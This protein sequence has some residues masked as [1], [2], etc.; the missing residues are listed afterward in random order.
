MPERQSTRW[1]RRKTARPA[2]ILSAALDCFAERGFAAT[3]LDDI[4]ARAG[5]TKGTLYLYFPSKEELFKAL[6]REELL[7]NLERLEAAASGPGTAA[8]LLGRLLSVWAGHVV[9]SRISVL[10]KLMIAEAGNFPELAR[11]YLREVIRRGLRLLRSILRRG[12]EAGEFRP[13]DVEHTTYCV[14]GPLLFSVLWKHSF[15]PH[16]DR[17]LDVSALCRAH[18]DALL[19]GLRRPTAAGRGKRPGRSSRKEPARDTEHR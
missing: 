12:V 1:R 11:F 7:P 19:N 2:E 17:P 16:A 5:V 6:V 13:I 14:I 9:A 15:E 18:L 10:P 8:D 4:A 3:R